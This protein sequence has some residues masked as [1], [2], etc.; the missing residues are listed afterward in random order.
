MLK[1]TPEEICLALQGYVRD[2]H[3]Y[4]LQ[5]YIQ[6]LESLEGEIAEI[7]R[8]VQGLMVSFDPV[9]Q[10]SKAIPAHIAASLIGRDRPNSEHQ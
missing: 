5:K 4:M 2:Q 7:D 10:R 8:R 6:L 9:R 3:L 1:H